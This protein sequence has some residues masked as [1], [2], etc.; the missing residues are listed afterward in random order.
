MR[1]MI[2]S[3]AATL[4]SAALAAALALAACSHTAPGV[5]ATP[6]APAAAAAPS[7]LTVQS[8]AAGEHG[9]HVTST[10]VLG[11]H[12]AVLVDAQFIDS[13]AQHV[14]EAVRAS[15]RR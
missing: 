3:S 15:G 8:Y 14:V 6:D 4:A 13:E 9:M 1:P 11:T 2:R 12:D 5:A 10:L 7:P